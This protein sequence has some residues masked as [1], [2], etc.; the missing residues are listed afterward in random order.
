MKIKIASLFLFFSCMLQGQILTDSNL[1]IVIITTD[2]DSTTGNLTE[3]VDSN[4]VLASMKIIYHP[5][6]T[7]NY[8]SDQNTNSFLNYNG[9]IKIQIRGSSSQSLPKK[10]YALTTLQSD[11]LTNNNVTILG[12]P[13]ENDWILNSLAFDS[14]L[15]RD[16]LSYDLSRD[17]GNYASK[18]KYCEVV[19]NGDYVGVYIFMEKIKIDSNRVNIIKLSNTDTT[20][21]N[22]TGG[23]ITK[24]D[25]TTGGDP[26]A[27]SY[28]TNTAGF[29]DFIHESPKPSNITAEQN[30][31]INSEF[32][33]LETIMNNQNQSI[34]DGFPSKIDIPSFIDFM[35]LNELA[36]NVDGYQYSTFFHKDRAGK[37]R[38]GPIWD[39]NLTY[40]NDLFFWGFDRSHTD[41]WQFDNG[42]NEG[43]K[44]WKNLF[45]NPTFKCYLSNRW[46]QSTAINKPL[47]YIVIEN[48]IDQLT[49]L[50]AQARIRENQ[51]WNTIPDYDLAINQLKSWL[52]T[53]VIW[54]TDNLQ[55]S[56]CNFPEVPPLVISKIHYNPI[57]AGG[58]TSNNLEF[59]ELTNNSNAL[60]DISGYYFRELG[61]TYIF[62]LNSMIN[63][64]QKIYLASNS[65]IFSTFY[66]INAFGQY[67]RNLSNKSQKLSLC[68]PYGTQVDFVE[69]QDASP[70]PTSPDGSGP[71]L[72]LINLNSD[73]A[74]ASNWT[75]SSNTLL[76]NS[77]FEKNN[78]Q[79]IVYPNPFQKNIS[80][81]NSKKCIKG[82][83][84]Y[85]V[86]GKQLLNFVATDSNFLQA[87]LEGLKNGTY[88]LKVTYDFESSTIKIIKN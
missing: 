33:S 5:D 10:P 31:Y 30:S 46:N 80:I 9:R 8:I 20:V 22:V 37:L 7:Q 17:L 2:V 15:I 18:G 61:L 53:R 19:V 41:V 78:Q 35:L 67:T 23:Y 60:I 69:Y 4:T 50:L 71:Y 25:K 68:D 39:F 47:N 3:I 21:P 55:V 83:E 26:I 52:Q 29:V 44:F 1:P 34:E 54:M 70:W 48:K 62:P 49:S 6:D 81:S 75:A 28:Q 38:A 73:N 32:D 87:N 88:Y 42:D 11:N 85:D 43:A 51:K 74:L 45:D 63:P 27:W 76:T 58:N 59:L 86:L 84:I 36:S 56:N 65:S 40:G 13:S 72:T 66:G 16:Y 64:N 12:M 14:S 79:T 57:V 82:Y 24:C 77:N